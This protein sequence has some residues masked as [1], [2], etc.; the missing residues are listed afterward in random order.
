MQW[1]RGMKS[2]LPLVC[3]ARHG[4]TAWTISRQHTGITDLPLT[5]AGEAE[6]IDLGE[7]LAAR[8]FG[9]VFTSPL[10]RAVRTCELA[11]HGS[12]AMA[13]PDLIE[14]NYGAYEGR[15]TREIDTER[16]SWNLLRDGCP[17]GEMPE[18]VGARA[19]RVIRSVR[20]I[21]G[22]V[23]L[24]SSAHFL[25]VFAA[26]WL[27]LEPRAGKYFVLGTGSLSEMGYE[28]DRSEPVIRLWDETHHQ[29]CVTLQHARERE[30]A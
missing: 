18:A 23:L 6:A 11:G 13:E 4:Q 10:R 3:L 28:H 19:D 7:R 26:R 17:G 30:T 24:F 14:W 15:T 5:A 20:A 12:V 22:D 25:R 29:C 21:D 9:A 27:G 1:R 8:S 2:A 16:P